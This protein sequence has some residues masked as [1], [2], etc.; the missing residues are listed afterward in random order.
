MEV[1]QAAILGKIVR[2]Y[3]IFTSFSISNINFQLKSPI[4]AG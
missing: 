1:K 3:I 4:F 2:F